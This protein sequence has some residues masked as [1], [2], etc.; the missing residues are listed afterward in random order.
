MV[1]GKVVEAVVVDES[2]A[3]AA[4]VDESPA[5]AAVP[6]EGTD[7]TVVGVGIVGECL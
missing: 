7:G 1:G 6:Q 3:V 5:A 4:A 2:P